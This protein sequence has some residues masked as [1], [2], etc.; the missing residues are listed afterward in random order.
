MTIEIQKHQTLMDIAIQYCGTVEALA[1][2]AALNDLETTD[3]L[4]PGEYLLIPVI[5]E[6]RVEKY[7]SDNNIQPVT[8]ISEELGDEEGIEFWGIEYDFIVS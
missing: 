6:E 4:T 7:F 8:A 2:L 3:D 1:E 5:Y